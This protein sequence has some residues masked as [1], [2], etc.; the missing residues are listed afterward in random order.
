MLRVEVAGYHR[1]HALRRRTIPTMSESDPLPSRNADSGFA[2]QREQFQQ[3]VEDAL[4]IARQLGASDAAAEVS[5]GAGLSVS[6]RK[7]EVENVER[8][9]DKSLGVTVYMRPAA[10]QREQLRLLAHRAASRPCAL[11]TT[12]RA[13][14]PKTRPPACPTRTTSRKA[15]RVARDLDLFHPWADRCRLRQSSSRTRCEARRARHRPAH[16]QFRRRRRVGAAVAF[17]GRQQPRLSRRL[18]ELAPFGVGGADRRPRRAAC[19]AT[20][21]TARC[22]TPRSSPRPKQWGATRPSA[23]C[24]ACIRA[25]S[26]PARC[27][28]CSSRRWPPGCSAPTCRRRAAARCTARRAS[29][30]TAS[31]SRSCAEHLDLDE[32]PHMPQGQ[33]QRAVRRRRRAHASA[34]RGD[35][36]VVQ[37]YFLSSYSARKLG[38]AHHRA[39]RRLAEPQADEPADAARATTSTR[40]CASCIAACSS[41]S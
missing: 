3:I 4:A 38:H 34:R 5:E 37:G 31:A 12:S 16:H 40:C 8:N 28:C 41:S 18:R 9:R 19:S 13:S 39:R 10:R 33:G 27:R 24:R 35:A 21:G 6:V 23:R 14:P 11:L 17:L 1:P 2:Y 26:R 22:A 25:R 7:G 36:G 20:P 15:Q 32:D 29:C 30:S